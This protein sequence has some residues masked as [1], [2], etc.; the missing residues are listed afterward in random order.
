MEG[1]AVPQITTGSTLPINETLIQLLLMFLIVFCIF[2]KRI[3]VLQKLKIKL[4]V[5]RIEQSL[6]SPY[7]ETTIV[8]EYKT[9]L[10]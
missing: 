4:R 1:Q 5:L 9:G 7:L 8:M 10:N 6:F 3:Q 2:S